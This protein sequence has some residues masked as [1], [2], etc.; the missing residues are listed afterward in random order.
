M[1]K[2]NTRINEAIETMKN[3]LNNDDSGF[4][5]W[6]KIICNDLNLSNVEKGVLVIHFD[7]CR[8]KQERL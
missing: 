6:F 4:F 2:T 5:Y 3:F 8:R 7:E 1:I